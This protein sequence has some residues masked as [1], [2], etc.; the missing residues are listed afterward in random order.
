MGAN[1]A[2][3]PYIQTNAQDTFSRQS[4]G[5]I[6][7][8]LLP[9]PSARYRLAGGVLAASETTPIWGGVGIS[10]TTN[11][12]T[13]GPAGGEL[14]GNITRATG[15]VGDG[16]AGDLTGFSVFDQ[17]YAAINTPQSPVPLSG[18]GG[19]VNFV[20]FGSQARLTVAIDPILAADAQGQIITQPVAWDYVNQMIIPIVTTKTVSSGTYNNTTGVI[21]LTMSAPITEFGAGGAAVLSGL[22]G[23]G[24]YATLDGTWTIA[25]VSGSTVVLDGPAGAGASTITG[26][27]LDLDSNDPIP[28]KIL[29]INQGNSM[30]VSYDAVTGFATWNRSGDTAVIQI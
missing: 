21:T 13:G 3:N 4:D 23:T 30:V 15:Y 8:C 22:T 10:E 9:D 11:P 19:L 27:S 2:L 17:N 6:V 12:V 25:S 28:V 1:V 20:R 29:Q 18:S 7:G 24:G 16:S 26:G 14:G 5:Y